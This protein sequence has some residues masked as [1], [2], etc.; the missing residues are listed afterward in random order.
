M[1]WIPTLMFVTLAAAVGV[2]MIQ[3]FAFLQRRSNR[4]AAENALAGTGS[5]SDHGALPEL[6]GLGAIAIV[7]MVLLT[8]GYN[9]R[10]HA[11]ATA[12]APASAATSA[13][14]TDQ[15][16]APA[17]PR[18][19]PAEMATPPT[20][21]PLGDGSPNTAPTNPSAMAPAHPATTGV[22]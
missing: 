13:S 5:R 2:A 22:K 12:A 17:R 19:N 15:M 7:A 10:G 8:A 6:A 16:T 9:G 11:N 3:L 4:D 1:Q 18:A 20:Q 14:A 21:Y